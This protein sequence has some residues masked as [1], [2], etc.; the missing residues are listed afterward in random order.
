M[1]TR[2]HRLKGQGVACAWFFMNQGE[3][4]VMGNEAEAAKHPFVTAA[5]VKES[6][7]VLSGKVLIEDQLTS[8]EMT[9]EDRMAKVANPFAARITAA[10]E[11]ESSFF[12]LGT[13]N[14]NHTVV[15]VHEWILAPNEE[16]TITVNGF[17][18]VAENSVIINGDD[19]QIR[20][21]IRLKGNTLT[22]TAGPEGA[23]VGAIEVQFAQ[24]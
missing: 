23:V 4:F 19:I 8:L 7:F 3:T 24:E 11:G 9:R 14:P 6:R 17:L 5:P 15:D 21:I 12:C 18:A 13:V 1:R 20:E 22:M 16:V 2:V 10:A